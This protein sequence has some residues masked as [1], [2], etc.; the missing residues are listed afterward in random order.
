MHGLMDE[1][2][3]MPIT[4]EAIVRENRFR[5]DDR[6]MG[7]RALWLTPRE[8]ESLLVLCVAS[9]V[10]AGPT[11]QDLFQKLGDYFRSHCR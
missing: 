9:P 4:A 1:A 3:G 10:S 2:M 7:C 11:E 5:A 6:T 8:A